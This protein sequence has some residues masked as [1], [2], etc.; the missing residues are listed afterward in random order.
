MRN[1]SLALLIWIA[2]TGLCR[3]EDYPVRA[4]HMIVPTGAGGITDV[5]ARLVSDR[6]SD[7][8][9]QSVIVEDRPGAGGISGTEYVA[10]ARADGY[11]LL[12]AF[13]SHAINPGLYR[14]L[15]YDTI[16]DFEPVTM[17]SVFP[18]VLDVRPDFPARTL[19]DL[20]ALAKAQSGPLNYASVGNGSL[21]FLSAELFGQEAGIRLVQ[22]PFAGTPQAN[23]A[24]MSGEVD[25]FFDTP[26]TSLPLIRAGKVRALGVT[27]RNR[28]ISLPDVPSVSETVRGYE[29]LG[30]NGVLAPKGTPNAIVGRLNQ[31]LVAIL[32]APA[33]HEELTERGVQVVGDT[34]AEFGAAIR[35][36][37]AKWAAVIQKAGIQ[38]R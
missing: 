24:L 21:A 18:C 8:T 1:L 35:S 14:K 15:P 3:A 25:I 2:A 30:W 28:Q 16:N 22:V 27:S 11:T 9:G 17:V 33:M 5:L 12:F 32:H 26:V 36:E 38:P 34:Q 6:L 37:T 20:I 7:V 10:R 23:A 31:L 19:R 13:P 4:I 29:A